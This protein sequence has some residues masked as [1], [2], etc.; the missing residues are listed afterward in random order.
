MRS[1]VF[2]KLETCDQGA[3]G[4]AYLFSITMSNSAY[5]LWVFTR[6]VEKENEKGECAKGG[7]V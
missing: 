1:Y 5:V 2:S 4:W 3:I 7:L 6:K